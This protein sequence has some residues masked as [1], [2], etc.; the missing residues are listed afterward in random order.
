MVGPRRNGVERDD[1]SGNWGPIGLGEAEDE[2]GAG[3]TIV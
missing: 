3:I 1:G 2:L